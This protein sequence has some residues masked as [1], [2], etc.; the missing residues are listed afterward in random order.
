[1]DF[2]GLARVL[3]CPT[4]TDTS[5]STNL[6]LACCKILGLGNADLGSPRVWK[7]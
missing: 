2:G 7:W 5:A 1:M 4:S 3:L 6:Q